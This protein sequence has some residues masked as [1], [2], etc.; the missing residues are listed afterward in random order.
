MKV[1]HINTHD[2][3]GAGI[4][5]TRL[6]LGISQKKLIDSSILFLS[7]PEKEILFSSSIKGNLK[8]AR[9]KFLFEQKVIF[10][11]IYNYFKTKK[12]PK[13]YEAF[14][15]PRTFID[16]TKSQQY[17]EADIIHLHWVSELMDYPSFFKK[18]KKP[19]VWTLHDMTPFSAGYPYEKGFPFKEYEKLN[20]Q[21][22]KIKKRALQ[23]QNVVSVSPSKWMMEKAKKSE[24]FKN[25]QHEVIK[26][27][28]DPQ[29]FKP[30]NQQL[31]RTFLE[32][33]LDKKIILF[34]SDYTS[35]KRKG[36][37]FLWD[38]V[39]M[40]KDEE[41]LLVCT[42]GGEMNLQQYANCISLGKIK[43]ERIMRLAYSAADV[44]VLPSIEDNL[45]NTLLESI[46]CG[47]P[48]VG[49]N[50]GGIKEIVNSNNGLLVPEISSLSLS[51]SLKQIINNQVTFD[52]N[53]IIADAK[54]KYDIHQ[55]SQKYIDL[56]NS[57]I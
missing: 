4:A 30:F 39:K 20:R 48:I 3:G 14:F 12:L 22:I 36:F 17:K 7:P 43:D 1:L 47:T 51:N 31:A 50:I 11:R 10:S 44:Y 54:L 32:L 49:F 19:I 45:P 29:L 40:L 15:L 46:L 55:Q 52:R 27:G 24:L 38:A 16:I 25:V 2:Y 23:S 21:C 53:L 56:Y 34:V 42:I 41:N 6:H 28:I 5:S 26:N 33:P 37:H 9:E 35:N 13:G 18:N 8:N 57:I